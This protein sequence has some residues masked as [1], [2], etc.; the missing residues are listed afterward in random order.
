MGTK[1][2]NSKAS[3]YE[4]QIMEVNMHGNAL[5]SGLI[6]DKLAESKKKIST[7]LQIKDEIQSYRN[8]IAKLK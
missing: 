4:R 2:K 7:R 8:E 6:C 5:V 1:N 3:V